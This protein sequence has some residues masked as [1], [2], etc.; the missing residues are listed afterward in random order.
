MKKAAL[1]FAAAGIAAFG[2]A[3][4]GSSSNSSNS[5]STSGGSSTAASTGSGQTV[6]FTP[7]PSGQLKFTNTAVTAKAGPATLEIDNQAPIAH[8]LVVEDSSGAQVGKTPITTSGTNS[9]DATLKP[10]TYT[11]FCDLPG[12]KATMHGTITVK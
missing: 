1:I 10:G 2:I 5:A 12:H 8:D 6:V 4:C 9:F 7:D 11:F 3:A